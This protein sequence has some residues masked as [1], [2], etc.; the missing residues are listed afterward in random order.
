MATTQQSTVA[1]GST[2]GF[3]GRGIDVDP[4]GYEVSPQAFVDVR[5][6][7]ADSTGVAD[8]T[9]AI[10]KT[11]NGL[12]TNGGAV[13][14]PAGTY[15]ITDAIALRSKL[16]LVGDGDGAS[17]IIQYTANKDAFSGAALSRVA[18]QGLYLQGTG[19]GTGSGLNLTKGA[20]AAVSYVSVRDVTFDSWGQ[21]GVAVENPIV[22]VFSRVVAQTC[23]RYGI[24]LYGQVAGAAGTSTALSGCY[25]NACGTAGIRL[26]NMSYCSLSGCAADHNPIGHLIDTCQSVALQGVGAEGNTTAGVKVN[27]GYG[28]TA[29]GCWVYDN[30]GIGIYVTGSANTVSLIGATDN[31]PNGTATAFIKADTGSHVTLMGCSNTTANS[32]ASGTAN[33]ASDASGAGQFQGYAALLAGGEFDAD[34]TCFVSSKGI[35]L[36]DRSDGH[37]YRLKVTAGVLAVE[38]AA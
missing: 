3:V 20:N 22:S 32:L 34:L 19:A 18:V 28:I 27:A 21:D 16:L 29:A 36:S 17:V 12:P 4:A 9:A 2:Y 8:S 38:Q 7:G 10:Q 26:Y 24:N 37:R 33:V 11:I 6:N 5:T 13:Y 14:F 30:R 35:V 15:K 25:G 31:T 23:G 1:T